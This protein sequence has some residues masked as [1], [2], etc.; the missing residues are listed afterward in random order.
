MSHL[1][2]Q[3][4]REK[5]YCLA[6]GLW[7]SEFPALVQIGKQSTGPLASVPQR[8]PG[9]DFTAESKDSAKDDT[10]QLHKYATS[11][12]VN[13]RNLCERGDTLIR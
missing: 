11:A 9:Q 3:L 5:I 10:R 1:K 6:K 2:S 8:Q 4:G 13:L 7:A 12:P